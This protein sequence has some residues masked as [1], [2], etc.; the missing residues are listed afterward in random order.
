M[1]KLFSKLSFTGL[2]GL[3]LMGFSQIGMAEEVA[4]INSGD[5]AWMIVAT[6]LVLVMAIPG[7]ALFYRGLRRSKNMLSVLMQVVVTVSLMSILWV[8]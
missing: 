5:T 4:T 1:T 7:L 3:L 8:V 2:M 6:I